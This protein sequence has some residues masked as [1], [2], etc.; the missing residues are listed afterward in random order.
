MLM[1]TLHAFESIRNVTTTKRSTSSSSSKAI[2][3][4]LHDDKNQFIDPSKLS[5]TLT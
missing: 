3:D 1:T 2:K 4:Y 5:L